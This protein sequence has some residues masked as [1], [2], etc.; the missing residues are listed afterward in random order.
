MRNLLQILLSMVVCAASLNAQGTPT[1]P[2]GKFSGYMIGDYYYN[3]QRDAG[4]AALSNNASSSA[5]PGAT[6][7]QSFLLRRIYL[8]YDNDISE[9]FTT[10][11][12]LEA[13]QGTDVLTSGKIG[14]F[15]KDAYLKWKNIFKGSDL[16]FGIQPPPTYDVSEAAWGYRSLEKTIMDLRGIYGSRDVGLSLKGKIVESGMFNYWVMVGKNAGNTPATTNKFNRYSAQLHIK[17]V[18]GLQ[19]TLYF[20][21]L[22]AADK[23]DPFN[24][25]SFVGN[26]MS[27]MT[28]FVGYAQP[29]SFNVGLEAFSQSTANGYTASGA[30]S[31]SSLTKTGFSGWASANITSDI[32]AVL[33]Y[34]NYDPNTNSIAVGD[35]RN[36]LIGGVAFKVNKN[37]SIIPNLLYETY[38]A[39]SGGSAPD[40]S[41]TARLT[42]YYIFL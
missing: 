40:A 38:K 11:F 23:A 12:R 16:T 37:V 9:E 17:P 1:A 14:V 31:L 2:A 5:A 32:A 22:D 4:Y 24:K 36:Y 7:M 28:L 29:N 18:T 25:G 35:V 13:D 30:T 3:V 39:P 33:R 15:V 10:R 41:V 34:D 42:F 20:D 6:A 8:T 26:A 27:T 21:Y 19:A